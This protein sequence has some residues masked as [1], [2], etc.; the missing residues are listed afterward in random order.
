MWKSRARAHALRTPLPCCN[1]A[2]VNRH[3]TQTCTCYIAAVIAAAN[4]TRAAEKRKRH[5]HTLAGTLCSVFAAGF[6]AREAAKVREMP[7]SVR[8]WLHYTETDADYDA[9]D[10]DDDDDV[11]AAAAAD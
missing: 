4:L 2:L 3:T 8:L 10:Y 6:C 5:T 1:R 7:V 11:A 9:G